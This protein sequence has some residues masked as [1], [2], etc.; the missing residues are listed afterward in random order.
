[1]KVMSISA[2]PIEIASVISIRMKDTVRGRVP[3]AGIS[4]RRA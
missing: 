3:A 1:M 2:S 4:P